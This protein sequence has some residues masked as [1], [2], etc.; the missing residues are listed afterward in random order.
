MYTFWSTEYL[1][2]AS[3]WKDSSASASA[4]SFRS[5]TTT[6]QTSTGDSTSQPRTIHKI[7]IVQLNERS[8]VDCKLCDNS[9]S[10]IQIHSITQSELKIH[11]SHLHQQQTETIPNFLASITKIY[12]IQ[13]LYNNLATTPLPIP[14]FRT[15]PNQTSTSASHNL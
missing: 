2:E 7:Y 8:P 15:T 10:H 1:Q 3:T 9:T 5:A 6:N 12:L 13:N 14:T 11:I 4:F